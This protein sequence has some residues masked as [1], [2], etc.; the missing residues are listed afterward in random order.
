[1]AELCPLL[2]LDRTN[3][4]GTVSFITDGPDKQ[5]RNC[6]LYYCWTGQTMKELSPL[7]LMDRTNNGGTVSF[8][9]AGSDKQ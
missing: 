7:L 1:M 5:W 9:I 3:N 4:E 8:I 2:L 6:V